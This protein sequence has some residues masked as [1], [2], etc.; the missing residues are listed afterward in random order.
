[1]IALAAT[2][3]AFIALAGLAYWLHQNNQD[4]VAEKQRLKQTNAAL[5]DSVE[6]QKSVADELKANIKSRDKL[7]DEH[8]EHRTQSEQKLEQ[9]RQDL[10]EALRGNECAGTDHPAA[11]GDWLRKHSDGL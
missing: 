9:A 4:L 3:S 5:A 10:R 6:N 8:I 2:G 7:A 11:V 1:M